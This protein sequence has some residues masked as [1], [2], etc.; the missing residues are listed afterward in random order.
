MAAIGAYGALQH[1]AMAS[2]GV[3]H[4]IGMPLNE[5]RRPFDVGEEKVTVP[6]DMA[7]TTRDMDRLRK[8]SSADSAPQR[9]IDERGP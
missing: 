2:Q 9:A 6:P 8:V 5:R 3:F 1:R 7:N 4:R